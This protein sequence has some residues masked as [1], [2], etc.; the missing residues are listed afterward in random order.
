MKRERRN[1]IAIVFMVIALALVF[2][3]SMA[4]M[5]AKAESDGMIRVRLTRLGAPSSITLAVEAGCHVLCEKPFVYDDDFLFV[6]YGHI[7]NAES[8]CEHQTVIRIEL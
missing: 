1:H 8:V 4:Y 5:P 2:V 7:F 6:P 3:G